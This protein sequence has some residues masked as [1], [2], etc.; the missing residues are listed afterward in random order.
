MAGYLYKLGSQSLPPFRFLVDVN[1]LRQWK[2]YVGYDHARR[3]PSAYPGPVDNANL[4][5]GRVFYC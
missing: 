1:W 2:K 3:R 4:F 5:R